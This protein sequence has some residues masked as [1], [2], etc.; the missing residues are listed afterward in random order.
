MLAEPLGRILASCAT[1]NS[2]RLEN[3][4]FDVIIAV[5]MHAARE[6]VRGYN[7]AQRLAEIVS[8][9]LRIPAPTGLLRRV[10]STK[11]QV[12]LAGDERRKNLR[13][14]FEASPKVAGQTILLIDDVSTTGSTLREC[15]TALKQA[16]AKGVYCLTLGAG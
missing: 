2:S 12:G 9:Q 4:Q 5:P 3:L 10:R 6:R 1:K 7:H 15:S 8:R 13:G 16:G 11:A 14:A